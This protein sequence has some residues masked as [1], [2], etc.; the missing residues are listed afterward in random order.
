MAGVPE[1]ASNDQVLAEALRWGVSRLAS[2]LRAEQPGN[3]RSLTRLA[4]SVLANLRHSGALT[5]SELAT[6]EGLQAQSLTRVLNE[7][8]EQGRIRRSR[9]EADARRQNIEVTEAGRE[10]LREHVRDGNAWLAAALRQ[11]LSPAERGVLHIAAELLEQ[12]AEAEVAGE[13]RNGATRASAQA[14]GAVPAL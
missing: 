5:P 8:E 10:A 14:K 2:R 13:G 9:S 6:I 3:G 11:T 4:A 1:E 12:V 7:L